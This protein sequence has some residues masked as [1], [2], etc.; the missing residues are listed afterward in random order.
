MYNQL[1]SYFIGNLE[2][3]PILLTF[4]VTDISLARCCSYL[5]GFANFVQA[6]VE[7]SEISKR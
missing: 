2:V 6:L 5:L 7:F 1:A 3:W 4:L